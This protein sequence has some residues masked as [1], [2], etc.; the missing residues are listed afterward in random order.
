MIVLAIVILLLAVSTLF[1][2][3]RF[4]SEDFPK[5]PAEMRT[6]GI[7]GAALSLTLVYP[8]SAL[9]IQRLHDFGAGARW[10]VLP[11]I[12]MLIAADLA[13]AF[14]GGARLEYVGTAFNL[15]SGLFFIVIGFIPPEAGSNRF[16]ANPRDQRKAT[17]VAA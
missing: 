16:G 14:G 4:A 3:A 12:L 11:L 1:G 15:I 9:A 6:M 2:F 7:L 13:F 5:S 10:Y 17:A 8:G